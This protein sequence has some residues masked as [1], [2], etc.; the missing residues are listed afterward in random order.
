M[1]KRQGR[2]KRKKGRKDQNTGSPSARGERTGHG[3][4]TRTVGMDRR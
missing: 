3:I 2:E 1:K 4:G